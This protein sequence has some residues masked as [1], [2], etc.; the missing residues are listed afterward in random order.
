MSEWIYSTQ[1]L[2]DKINDQLDKIN[3]KPTKPKEKTKCKKKPAKIHYESEQ[4][5]R[6]IKSNRE[7]K[8]KMFR[9]VN[10]A[11]IIPNLCQIKKS[12]N[13]GAVSLFNRSFKNLQKYN[14]YFLSKQM[15][16]MFFRENLPKLF[17]VSIFGSA[18]SS[19]Y[20]GIQPDDI[21]IMTT[22]VHQRDTLVE[23]MQNRFRG[24]FDQIT[25]TELYKH[26]VCNEEI[27]NDDSENENSEN[28]Y[29][30][31]KFMIKETPIK[32][33]VFCY[34]SI[35][36]KFDIITHNVAYS[37][38]CDFRQNLC[39][40]N[41]KTFLFRPSRHFTEDQSDQEFLKQNISDL[42]NKI[43][44][45][46]QC[47]HK[48]MTPLEIFN[49]AVRFYKKR[50]SGYLIDESNY[51]MSG[52]QCIITYSLDEIKN[53]LSKKFICTDTN[54]IIV[55]YL[56][57]QVYEKNQQCT[58]CCLPLDKDIL[59]YFTIMTWPKDQISPSNNNQVARNVICLHLL[60]LYGCTKPIYH[61]EC[62][63]KIIVKLYHMTNT[64]SC[65]QSRHNEQFFM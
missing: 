29:K 31:K 1:S 62:F 8:F 18:V 63:K 17:N 41:S 64:N 32:S 57:N 25:S 21:D 54:Q 60:D 16:I 40:D 42:K 39:L 44:T 61:K 35:R 3:T 5:V 50:V 59:P 4:K 45:P 11:N 65:K 12:K 7:V 14:N 23:W 46:C 27:E 53:E 38:P 48:P 24:M 2:R 52:S 28:D 56:A 20:S 22:S 43:L 47:N 37:L 58:S 6:A 36:L 10:Q 55:S 49:S 13:T 9:E 33:Y 34:G 15:L 26:R 30:K 51:T 19:I